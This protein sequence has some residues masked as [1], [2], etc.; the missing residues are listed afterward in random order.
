MG[1][2]VRISKLTFILQQPDWYVAFHVG[3]TYPFASSRT[4]FEL[5]GWHS[6]FLLGF[7]VRFASLGFELKLPNWVF[8]TILGVTR[9]SRVTVSRLE[10]F[11]WNPSHFIPIANR[12]AESIS[13]CKLVLRFVGGFVI[14]NVGA[15]ALA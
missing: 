7:A 15:F 8:A 4:A 5:A 12:A 9:Y 10:L 14:G 3:F 13:E 2:N 1:L 6:A 11:Y